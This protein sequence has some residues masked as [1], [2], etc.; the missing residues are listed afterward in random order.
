MKK[1]IV[2][3]FII[4]FALSSC[5]TGDNTSATQGESEMR[6][7]TTIKNKTEYK[8]IT[9]KEAYGIMNSGEDYILLDVRTEEEYEEIRIDGA[10]LIPDYEIKE[11]APKLLKDTDALILVYCRSGRRSAGAAE[12]L[13]QMGYTNIHDIGGIIDWPYDTVSG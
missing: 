3:I 12:K 4:L 13:A 8:K 9:P 10:L 5:M 7:G 11:K 1:L 6:I 2:Y